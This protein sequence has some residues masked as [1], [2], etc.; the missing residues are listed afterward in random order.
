[1]TALLLFATAG[2]ARG[3]ESTWRYTTKDPGENW[4]KTDAECGP[5]WKTGRGGFGRRGTPG[6]RIGTNWHT[7][8]IW[9]RGE[10]VLKDMKDVAKLSLE[11]CHDEDFEVYINGI[12]AASAKGY[13]VAYKIFPISPEAR[14]ALK[15]GK[16]TVAVHCHQTRG[17][18]YIDVG[19][20]TK[21]KPTVTRR[22]PQPVPE[23]KTTYEKK[24]TWQETMLAVRKT[25]LAAGTTADMAYGSSVL[26][27]V[28]RDFP[29]QADWFMQD[30][31]GRKAD[32]KQGFAD[33]KGD[34]TSYLQAGRDASLERNLIGKVL[35]ECGR[36]ETGF[37]KEL[38]EL[39]EIN[40]RPEDARWLDLY[41]RCC[42]VRRVERLRPL[43]EKAKEV[44]FVRHHNMGGGF[45]AYTEY[46]Q[47]RGNI[48][49][50]LF[51]LDLSNEAKA[52]GVFA[53]PKALIATKTDAGSTIRDPALSYDAKRLLFAWRKDRRDHYRV[54]ERDLASGENRL[55]TGA[56]THGASYDPVYLPDGN[57]MF[58][59]TRV[60]QSVD[61]AG[62]DVSNFF[63]CNRDGKFARRVG[64]DQVH[65]LWPT[66][67][68][69]GRVV[70]MRWDYNDRSQIYTQPL[71]QMNPDGTGQTEYY[72]NNSWLPTTCFH[73]RG[74][75]GTTKVMC[76]IG[77]HHN[78]QCG[79]LAIIDNNKGQ[80]ELE[81]VTEIPTGRRPAYPRRDA[82]AQEGDQFCYPF[83]L[84]EESLL[85]SYD[86]I[87]Y[88]RRRGRWNNK[89]EMRFHIYF[90]TTDGRREVLAADSR[91]SS[92]EPI[93][94]MPRKVP[95]RRPSTVDHRKKTGTYFVQDLYHGPGLKGI[96]RGTIKKLRVV[97][98][99][100]REMSI[101]RNG[102]NGKGG[103][104]TV[105]TPIATGRGSWDV[106][107]ILGDATVHEDG[108]A[109]F[110]VPAKTPVYF[111]ALNEKNQAI[112]T[113]RSW[114]T[115]MP[116]ERFSCV[117][118]HEHKSDAPPTTTRTSTAMKKGPEKLRPFYGP[119]RGFSFA[120]EVQPVLDKHCI[121]CHKANGKEKA[122]DYILTGESVLYR[123][124]KR[125]WSR[126]Y[127]TLTQT[128]T[129]GER[130]HDRGKPSEIVNW[131]NNSSEPSMIPP[132]YGGSTRSKLITMCEKGHGEAKLSQEEM[133]KLNAWI[134]LLVPFC[135][136]YVEANAWSESELK[137]AQARIALSK[138]MTE[139]DE[140]NV[141]NLMIAGRCFS[142]F[143]V[144][145][146]GPRVMKTCGQMGVA[147]GYAASRCVKHDTTPRIVGRDHIKELRKLCGYDGKAA[148]G[149]ADVEIP[150]HTGKERAH[151]G[152]PHVAFVQG[153]DVDVVAATN[154]ND[155]R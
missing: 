109:M 75:P 113:M 16:N 106:K 86:P 94:V 62:P 126:S 58:A 29:H 115:L 56:D 152:V 95:H 1:M 11:V 151:Y 50:G 78:P 114:S 98:L 145:L 59:S 100:F 153:D 41:V 26:R 92:M 70:Y 154:G 39:V 31:A 64:F 66:V 72:G 97:E 2:I 35:A 65:T 143:H 32:W 141:E 4:E 136:D 102:S 104:A 85:V 129:E 119:P 23:V 5:D 18:Q 116:G 120:R 108:S 150:G 76:A 44:I 14:K 103:G 125:N 149:G 147:T 99:R 110:E 36:R 111:Q 38:E 22:Q 138:K 69:D 140:K 84:D 10:Y 74:I 13:I 130:G 82:Y 123:T 19:F 71:F 3:I 93:P 80:Q 47:W 105:V 34:Y 30:R 112:Q 135:G 88:Y 131:I 20:T 63:I 128:P 83:P 53:R 142:C 57:I 79:K 127:L 68:D 55:I 40:A 101:G 87:A 148:V 52:D 27:R 91:I 122:R 124:A 132:R 90:M 133:D 48:F 67:L 8:D 12:L 21:K 33:G 134:D 17:G 24:G 46:T 155:I 144:G 117:G 45:F 139:M 89:D 77:G 137:R 9:L 81:G 121:K 42:I 146:G 51:T 49:G 118:C 54:Y 73:P 6:G 61:C 25:T 43:L 15:L 28:W 60:V 7:P 37:K 96:P 107:V